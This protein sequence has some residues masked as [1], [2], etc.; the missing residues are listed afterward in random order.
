MGAQPESA[1]RQLLD[2]YIEVEANPLVLQ[3]QELVQ[4][5]ELEQAQQLMTQA[6]EQDPADQQIAMDLIRL[7]VMMDDIDKAEEMIQALPRELRESPD[8]NELN[9]QI[10]F[11]KII[12]QSPEPGVLEQNIQND[13]DDLGSRHQLAAWRVLEGEYEAALEQLM[14]IMKQQPGWQEDA[15]RKN[16]LSIFEMIP[17]ATELVGKYRRQMFNLLH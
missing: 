6:L 10:G 13:P 3:A 1:L 16:M 5:G 11:T 14:Q 2:Q 8:I 12:Q 15:A 9:A 17:A 4:Q 7:T